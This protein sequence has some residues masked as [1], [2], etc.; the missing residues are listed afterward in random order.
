MT[1]STPKTRPRANSI[2]IPVTPNQASMMGGVT[3]TNV[4][5]KTGLQTGKHGITKSSDTAG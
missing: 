1:Q 3:V 4:P 2:V 5:I